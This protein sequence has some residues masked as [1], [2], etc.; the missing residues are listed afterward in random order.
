[1][2]RNIATNDN[3]PNVPKKPRASKT[4]SFFKAAR[5]VVTLNCTCSLAR[6]VG[7]AATSRVTEILELSLARLILCYFCPLVIAL[8]VD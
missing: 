7:S 6:K 8:C 2:Q 5:C 3:G 1:M 4:K